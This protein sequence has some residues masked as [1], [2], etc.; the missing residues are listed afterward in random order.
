M[1][2]LIDANVIIRFLLNDIPEQTKIASDIIYD[3]AFTIEAVIA[4]VVY[5]LKGV[6]NLSKKEISEKILEL[7]ELVDIEHIDVMKKTFKLFTE[8][9]LDFVDCLLISYNKVLSVDVFSFD[10]KLNN[11]L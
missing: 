2:K 7:L 4:E 3:G 6:Y 5:V 8:S 1:A 11:K 10:K 9:S